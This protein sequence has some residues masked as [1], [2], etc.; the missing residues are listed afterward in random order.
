MM[1]SRLAAIAMVASAAVT[2]TAVGVVSGTRHD[3]VEIALGPQAP[4]PPGSRFNE[5]VAMPRGLVGLEL[6]LGLLDDEPTDWE[7]EVSVSAGEVLD[8]TVL[9]SGTEAEDP[10]GPFQR[11]HQEVHPGQEAAGQEASQEAAGQET[12]AKKQQAKKAAGRT[13][14][15]GHD[16]RQPRRPGRR[17][18]HCHDRTRQVLGLPR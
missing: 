12:T 6:A 1:R 11:R 17:D 13:D 14:R 4:E 18:G 16:A 15:A 10:R 5:R 7:G 8:V 2:F 3:E 9:E